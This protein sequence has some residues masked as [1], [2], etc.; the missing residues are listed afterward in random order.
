MGYTLTR[1]ALQE[2][3][4]GG[5]TVWSCRLV[6]TTDDPVNKPAKALIFQAKDPSDPATRSWFS[7]VAR[8]ADL[9]MYPEDAPAAGSS[10]GVQQPYFRLDS[11]TLVSQ[12]ASELERV[13]A[14]FVE[15]L[16]LLDRNIDSMQ[17]LNTPEVIYP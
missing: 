11:V 3:S 15:H 1:E 5:K 13:T 14:Q 12:N 4:I 7:A 9:L 6:V 17:N 10:G 2:D 16:R 8:P